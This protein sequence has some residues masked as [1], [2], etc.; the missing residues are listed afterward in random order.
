MAVDVEQDQ[1]GLGHSTPPLIRRRR[2]IAH[3]PRTSAT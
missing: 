1:I 3:H 2:H